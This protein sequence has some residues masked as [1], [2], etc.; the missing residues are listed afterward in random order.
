MIGGGVGEDK[1]IFFY[2][3]NE[4]SVVAHMLCWPSVISDLPEY[5]CDIILIRFSY[6]CERDDIVIRGEASVAL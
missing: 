6:L 2:L 3:F 1:W 5:F 4:K